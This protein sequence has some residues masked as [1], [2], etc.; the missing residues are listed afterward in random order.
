LV[1]TVL[2]A[3]L[4]LASRL[5]A[6]PGLHVE[7]TGSGPVVVLVHAF[8]MDLRQWNEQMP[9]LAGYRVARYDVRGHGKSGPPGD[10]Y[11]AHED[12]AAL[13]R[14]LGV[15]RASIVGHSMGG[16]IA[17]DFA[18]AHP[19]SVDR[20]V[21]ISPGITGFAAPPADWFKPIIEAVRAGQAER[22][23]ELWWQ[24]P[25]MAGVRA[26]GAAGEPYKQ[27][28]ME[29]A[30]IWTTPRPADAPAQIPAIKRL[31]EL[32]ARTLVIVGDR[33]EPPLLGLTQRIAAEAP[34]ARRVEM[35]DT[36]HMAPLERPAEFN[37]VLVDFLRAP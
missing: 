29:N 9:A 15:Q 24:S 20:L 21:L 33:D 32:K 11:V 16:Q 4:A 19:E 28:V 5:V 3:I 7:T 26:R 37:R 22:A 14:D 8:H 6:V 31:A 25:M 27:I 12:L 23:G 35:K 30:G 2:P 1:V 36:G 18:L 10:G 13:L 17:V 34:N